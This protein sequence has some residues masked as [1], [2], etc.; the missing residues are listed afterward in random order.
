MAS[1]GGEGLAV[2]DA[3]RAR[4]AKALEEAGPGAKLTF[5]W[6]VERVSR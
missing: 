2:L 1:G 4:M 3:E 5:T 6:T